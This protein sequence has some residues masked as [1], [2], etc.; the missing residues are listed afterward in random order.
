[1]DDSVLLHSLMGYN[2]WG[3]I[4]LLV[5]EFLHAEVVLVPFVNLDLFIS[6]KKKNSHQQPNL[7]VTALSSN[8]CNRAQRTEFIGL[9]VERK[10][11]CRKS[12]LYTPIS[13]CEF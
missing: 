3:L 7:D 6:L 12:L 8:L 10:V 5:F 13:S 9:P 2:C 11:G 1:M 4:K